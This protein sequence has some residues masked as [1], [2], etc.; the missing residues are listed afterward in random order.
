[1]PAA[2]RIGGRSAASPCRSWYSSRPR[3]LHGRRDSS[4]PRTAVFAGALKR[5]AALHLHDDRTV[6]ALPRPRKGALILRRIH[7]A[8]A[9]HHTAGYRAAFFTAAQRSEKH[10]DQQHTSYSA[11]PFHRQFLRF[12]RVLRMSS[13]PARRSPVRT[14]HSP[15]TGQY[16]RPAGNTDHKPAACKW[17][18]G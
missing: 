12:S 14:P 7:H 1:M 3:S 18:T 4:V 17:D 6:P 5:V 10:H 13:L 16:P 15:Y 9:V 11:L 2:S 8:G